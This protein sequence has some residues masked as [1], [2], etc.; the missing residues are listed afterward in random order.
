MQEPLQACL[1]DIIR[2]LESRGLTFAVIGGLAV[3]LRAEPRFTADIDIVVAADL[4]DPPDLLS[5]TPG[6]TFQPLLEDEAETFQ[7]FQHIVPLIHTPTGT[8]VDLAIG[9]SGFEQQAVE[10]AEVIPLFGQPVRVVAAEDLLLF[11]VMA[12][13]ARDDQDA[14]N[15]LLRQGSKLDWEYLTETA[16]GLDEALAMGISERLDELRA[17]VQRWLPHGASN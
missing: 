13:R 9:L 8:K 2:L 3:S 16:A 15:L 4:L 5:Y 7:E 12:G 17:S 1:I 14:T 11:K 10:R 6:S